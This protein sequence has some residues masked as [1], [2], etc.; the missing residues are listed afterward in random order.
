[1][2]RHE[3]IESFTFKGKH[4]IETVEWYLDEGSSNGDKTVYFAYDANLYPLPYFSTWSNEEYKQKH[5]ELALKRCKD[6]IGEVW[7][8]DVKV[9][10][11]L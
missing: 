4:P 7:L 6:F 2:R 1:M 5:I 8:D 10:G 3:M 11:A 9:R